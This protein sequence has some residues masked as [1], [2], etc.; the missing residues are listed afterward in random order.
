MMET[1]GRMVV[2]APDTICISHPILAQSETHVG[3]WRDLNQ[4]Y[5]RSLI[6]APSRVGLAI[7]PH[8]GHEPFAISCPSTYFFFIP[9]CNLDRSYSS[10]TDYQKIGRQTNTSSLSAVSVSASSRV[11][12]GVAQVAGCKLPL[13]LRDNSSALLPTF[14]CFPPLP[15]PH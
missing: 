13:L 7:C 2:S 6:L 9:T 4:I 12:V 1:E 5:S 3:R 10:A 11:C 8:F 15:P 14:F